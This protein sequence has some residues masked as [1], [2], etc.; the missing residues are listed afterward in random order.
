MIPSQNDMRILFEGKPEEYISLYKEAIDEFMTPDED[1]PAEFDEFDGI[2]NFDAE[3][4]FEILF[5]IPMTVDDDYCDVINILADEYLPYD[6]DADCEE[7]R[8]VIYIDEKKIVADSRDDGYAI[9]RKFNEAIGSGFEIRVMKLSLNEDN[10]HSLLILSNDEW[11]EL[12]TKYGE[13]VAEYFEKISKVKF[14]QNN[15]F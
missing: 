10:V 2:E 7:D 15:N 1:V 8:T 9:I 3:E 14:E 13:K 12:D 5:T 11:K 4:L 6:V